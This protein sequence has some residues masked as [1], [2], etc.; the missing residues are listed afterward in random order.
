MACSYEQFEQVLR[1]SKFYSAG[2][3][4]GPGL[5]ILAVVSASLIVVFL[6]HSPKWIAAAYVGCVVGAGVAAWAA[7]AW[8]LRHWEARSSKERDGQVLERLIDGL[9]AMYPP[10]PRAARGELLIDL[11]AAVEERRERQLNPGVPG[12][13][14]TVLSACLATALSTATAV[15]PPTAAAMVA[16]AVVGATLFLL[17]KRLVDW[18]IPSRIFGHDGYVRLLRMARRRLDLQLL[19][20]ERATLPSPPSAD[21]R[22]PLG[23]RVRQPA[24]A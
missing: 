14:S 7:R 9:L 12:W 17:G 10:D 1:P 15:G 18:V 19:A 22:R 13:F 6:G 16:M 23:A 20:S 3:R 5:L 21:V 8:S 11:E 24:G 4:R 2:I